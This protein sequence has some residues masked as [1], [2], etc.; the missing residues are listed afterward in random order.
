MSTQVLD[1]RFDKH[2]NEQG[3]NVYI[4]LMLISSQMY[5]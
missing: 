2:S 4:P 1:A 5:T 3:D